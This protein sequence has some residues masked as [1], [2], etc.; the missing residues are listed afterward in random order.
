MNGRVLARVEGVYV[1]RAVDRWAG[2][3]PSA[4][5]KAPVEDRVW[6]GP[7]GFERDEQADRA[8]HGGRDKALHHY[9]AEHFTLWR[10][11]VPERDQKFFPGGFG[12]NLSTTGVTEADLC[13]GDVIGL[14]DAVIQVSHGRQPCWK[15]AAHVDQSDMAYRVQKTGRTGW[16]YRVL[17]PGE[18]GH[19]DEMKLVERVQPEWTLAR[20]IAARFDPRLDPAEAAAL[21]ALPELADVWRQAFA[22]K[23][24]PNFAED[25]SPRLKGP[26][27]K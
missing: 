1:G 6:L 20:V 12:E 10:A 14:G 24:D 18:I 25:A 17:E 3:P 9:P 13:I 22:K 27:E 15:L 21:A 4:I 16:Y 8:V 11:E 23:T 7:E 5:G 19:G 2:K 26:Q